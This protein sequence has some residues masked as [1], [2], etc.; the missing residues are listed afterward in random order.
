MGHDEETLVSNLMYQHFSQAEIDGVVQQIVRAGGITEGR[1]LFPAVVTA[2]K[3]WAPAHVQD[4]FM[5]TVPSPVQYLARVWWMPQY[6]AH[7]VRLLE[8]I[9]E[10]EDFARGPKFVCY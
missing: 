10:G 7:D 3:K 1:R 9:V 8:S 6:L 5:S 4:K 2:M